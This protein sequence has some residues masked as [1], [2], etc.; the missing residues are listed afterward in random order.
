MSI[1]EFG[2]RLRRDSE[3]NELS[4]I[5][6]RSASKKEVLGDISYVEIRKSKKCSGKYTMRLVFFDGQE[7]TFISS[8]PIQFSGF[9]LEFL[10]SEKTSQRYYELVWGKS[11]C[12]QFSKLIEVRLVADREA[13]L[14]EKIVFLKEGEMDE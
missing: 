10:K 13:V 1:D 6:Q 9:C 4:L 3:T 11:W 8:I 12:Y 7:T 14:P 5:Y 2:H